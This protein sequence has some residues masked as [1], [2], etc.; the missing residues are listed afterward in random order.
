MPKQGLLF[1][2]SR[3]IDDLKKILLG[4]FA[5]RT[6]TMR[7]IYEQ[8]NVDTPYVS[9]NYK[10]VLWELEEEGKITASKHRKGTFGDSVMVTFPK[11]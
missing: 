2:L 11:L 8:H 1:Q 10:T 6:L 3:P 7:E 4:E 5:G 9:K